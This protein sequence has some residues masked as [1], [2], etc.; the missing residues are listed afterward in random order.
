MITTPTLIL[1]E[2]KC[3]VNIAS[4]AERAKRFGVVLRPHFKTPQSLE[5]GRWFKEVGVTKITVSSFG[6]ANY[7]APEWDDI[8][9]AFPVNI[10]EIQTINKLAEKI[11]LSILVES[12]DSLKYLAEKLK[13]KVNFY[14]KIDSG[15]N[16]AGLKHYDIEGVE[17]LLNI[18]ESS[19]KLEFIGF[20]S[21][22]GHTYKCRGKAEVMSSHE[23]AKNKLVSIKNQFISK[24][25]NVIAS[26]GDTPSC[27]IAENFEGIDEIRPGNYAFYDLTQVAIG[28]CEVKN[29]AVALE[30]PIVAIHEK[31]GKLI[32]YGGGIHLSKDRLEDPKHGVIFGKVAQKTD[33]GWGELIPD[34]YLRGISQEHGVVSV[35]KEDISNYK[36][37]DTLMVLPIHSCMTADLMKRY[38]TTNREIITMF[39]SQFI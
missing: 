15:S 7:F 11:N 14:I 29:V 30:C 10:L 38:T 20:L 17:N 37:G 6:M 8:T 24:Y 12:L 25:P 22:A 34:T 33:S 5:I 2:E 1:D 26:Y 9:V 27:S 21:H 32:I 23:D 28:S 19:D 31:E 4:M 16:R 39:N 3:K 13:F 18:S 35:P 36:V